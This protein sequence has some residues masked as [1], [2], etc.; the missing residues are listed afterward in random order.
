MDVFELIFWI[1]VMILVVYGSI[2]LGNRID[3]FSKGDHKAMISGGSAY[4]KLS[5]MLLNKDMWYPQNKREWNIM[6]TKI[7]LFIQLIIGHYTGWFWISM[8]FAFILILGHYEWLRED[9]H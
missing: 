7:I 2:K 1:S 3:R 8:I 4:W 6:I 9:G 5:F